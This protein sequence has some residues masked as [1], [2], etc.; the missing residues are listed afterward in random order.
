[1]VE[2]EPAHFQAG[3]DN[4]ARNRFEGEFIQAFVGPDQFEVDAFMAEHPGLELDILHSDIDL[5][6]MNMLRC[7]AKTLQDKRAGYIFVSTHSQEL[8]HQVVSAFVMAGYRIEVSC[9]FDNET[10]SFDGF[11]LA[12]SPKRKRVFRGFKALSRSEIVQSKPAD[13]V[14]SIRGLPNQPFW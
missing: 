4:F 12:S 14:K 11:V 8:H 6:E 13:L 10:T 3:K 2:P 7:A 1:M 5:H 9:D